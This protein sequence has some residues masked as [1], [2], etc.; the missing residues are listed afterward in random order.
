MSKSPLDKLSVKKF[1]MEIEPQEVLLDAL[2]QRQEK[3]IGI[4]EKKNRSSDFFKNYSMRLDGNFSF[5]FSGLPSE[6][7]FNLFRPLEKST[8]IW[9]SNYPVIYG[10]RQ[11][12]AIWPGTRKQ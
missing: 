12:R 9:L 8:G 2:S 4:S 6:T 10:V 7:P 3:E 1:G 11:R 5:I